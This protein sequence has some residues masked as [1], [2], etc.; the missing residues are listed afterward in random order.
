M[1]N[2][3]QQAFRLTANDL[4]LEEYPPYASDSVYVMSIPTVIELFDASKQVEPF[5]DDDDAIFMGLCAQHIDAPLIHD[6]RFVIEDPPMPP[7]WT[8]YR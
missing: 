1:V 5:L 7:S 4:P 8:A 6:P 2:F 3:Q